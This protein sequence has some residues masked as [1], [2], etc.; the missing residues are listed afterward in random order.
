MIIADN[1]TLIQFLSLDTHTIKQLSRRPRIPHFF[2]PLGNGPYFKS[3]GVPDS[4]VHIMDWWESK[5]LEVFSS[6][7]LEQS[8][9]VAVDIICTP[10]QHFTGRG[11]L[12]RFKTLWSSWVVEE[13]L[14][15]PKTDSPEKQ[16]TKSSSKGVKVFFGG[17]TG[18]RSVMEG[19]D[20]EKVPV[21]PA[22]EEIGHRFG[23]FDFA[24]IPIGYGSNIFAASL[25]CH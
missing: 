13:V 8:H 10:A 7:G 21:C 16:S 23:G 6:S 3:L 9:S 1:K 20:E 25:A 15:L 5:R 18:Y 19:Q 2:A 24:M 17:D 4:H 22:F 12:D 11:I 14:Q